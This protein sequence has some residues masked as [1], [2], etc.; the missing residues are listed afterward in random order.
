MFCGLGE[1]EHTRIRKKKRTKSG[2]KKEKKQTA[3]KK[4]S[5]PKMGY[6]G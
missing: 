1:E 6:K 3:K 4:I 2:Q 5:R